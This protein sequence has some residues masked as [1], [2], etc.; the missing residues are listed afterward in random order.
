MLIFEQKKHQRRGKLILSILHLF[1]AV[2]SFLP[3]LLFRNV[4]EIVSDGK[5]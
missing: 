4:D 5:G 1:F 2:F 3:Y